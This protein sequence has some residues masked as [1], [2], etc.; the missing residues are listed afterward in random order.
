MTSRELERIRRQYKSVKVL[1]IMEILF[2]ILPGFVSLFLPDPYDVWGI[3]WLLLGGVVVFVI[4]NLIA[5]IFELERGFP[6][7]GGSGW[8][9]YDPCNDPDNMYYDPGCP[10]SHYYWEN[11]GL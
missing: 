8:K 4:Y 3:L 1:V 10:E 2:H 6:V 7:F 5:L 9:D 11:R